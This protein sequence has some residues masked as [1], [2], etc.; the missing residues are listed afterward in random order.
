M[1]KNVAYNVR[2]Q[3][4]LNEDQDDDNDDGGLGVSFVEM[5]N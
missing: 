5:T 3:S 4:V 2:V 1:G